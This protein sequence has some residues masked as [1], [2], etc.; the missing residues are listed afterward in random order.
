MKRGNERGFTLIELMVVLA[1]MAILVAVALPA[2]NSQVRH[3]RRTE[4]LQVLQDC[5]LRQER[6]RADNPTYG[7]A[8]QAGCQT[9]PSTYYTFTVTGNTATAFSAI[10]TVIAT[11][12]QARDKQEGVACSPLSLNQARAKGP[13][14]VCWK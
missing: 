13:N 3:S 14:P 5:A 11:T 2:Y 4:A 1:I 6:Y 8:V 12:D 10:A 7:T 9:A